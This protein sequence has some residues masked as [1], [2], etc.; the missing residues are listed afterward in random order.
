MASNYTTNYNL[1]QWQPTDQVQRTDFNADNA[2][3]DAALAAKAEAA[4]LTAA[5]GRVTALENTRATQTALN[6]VNATLTARA[7]ALDE[8]RCLDRLIDYTMPSDAAALDLDLSQIQASDYA[9]LTLMLQAKVWGPLRMRLNGLSGNIYCPLFAGNS[10]QYGSEITLSSETGIHNLTLFCSI[11][12]EGLENHSQPSQNTTIW[13]LIGANPQYKADF[14]YTGGRCS[15]LI[16]S[17]LHTI[18]LLFLDNASASYT[19][20]AGS[21]FRVFGLH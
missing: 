4:A 21:R 17:Q 11:W 1:C 19:I 13:S 10:G 20:W 2:K 15:P 14:I 12:P 3:L 18:N 7:N 9:S 5:V 8:A 16:Y 6:Q